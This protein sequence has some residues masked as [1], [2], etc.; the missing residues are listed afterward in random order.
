MWV[1]SIPYFFITILSFFYSEDQADQLVELQD[2]LFETRRELSQVK[3]ERA[4][5][6]DA[7]YTA[8]HW[9]DEVDALKQTAER[10]INLEAENEKLKER[11]HE[12]D[13]YKVN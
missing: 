13:Y 3:E 9:Q 11:L 6:A 10:V 8:R 12:I 4:R 1:S 7:A 2:H 5:L